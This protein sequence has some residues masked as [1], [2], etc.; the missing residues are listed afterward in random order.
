MIYGILSSH[1]LFEDLGTFTLSR[2]VREIKRVQS[3]KEQQGQGV[4]KSPRGSNENEV[5]ESEKSR[6]LA[7]ES[8][9]EMG[10]S[11]EAVD[12]EPELSISAPPPMSPTTESVIPRES[13]TETSEKARGKQK[14]RRSSSTD[15]E[16]SLERVAAL[17][18]GRNGFV[19]S[20]EWVCLF[21]DPAFTY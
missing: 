13:I 10:S 4:T 16:V 19:P 5:R 20:Q 14:E 9:E 7:S 8:Q 12:R 21:Y 1:K 11:G 6:L 15:V 2:A 18:I 3:L 17:G